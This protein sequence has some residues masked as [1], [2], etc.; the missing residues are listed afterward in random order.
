MNAGSGELETTGDMS[1][2]WLRAQRDD[3]DL[4]I[5]HLSRSVC[6]VRDIACNF[7]QALNSCPA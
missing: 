1:V 3:V 6:I 7:A 4:W 5:V 2:G